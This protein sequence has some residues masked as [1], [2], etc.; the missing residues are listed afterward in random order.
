[1]A[2]MATLEAA[3]RRRTPSRKTRSRNVSMETQSYG[4]FQAWET[5]SI[6]L[7]RLRRDFACRQRNR[8]LRHQLLGDRRPR[9]VQIRF[10]ARPVRCFASARGQPLTEKPP[11]AV[12]QL[13][14]GS[15]MKADCDV[16]PWE[17]EPLEARRRFVLRSRNRHAGVTSQLGDRLCLRIVVVDP[18][19]S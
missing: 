17:V 11:I 6:A 7:R 9:I 18:D 1:M 13:I 10:V 3:T 8:D 19:G 2:A 15:F 5:K 16:A 12:D 14:V 4:I